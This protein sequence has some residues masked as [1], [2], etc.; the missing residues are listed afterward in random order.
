MDLATNQSGSFVQW[1]STSPQNG[2]YLWKNGHTLQVFNNMTNPYT[3]LN[4]GCL[5]GLVFGVNIWGANC[6]CNF[7]TPGVPVPPGDF[8]CN[9]FP[10]TDPTSPTYN[11]DTPST[12]TLVPNGSTAFEPSLNLPGLQCNL[13]FGN[14]PHESYDITCVNGSNAI[15][16]VTMTPPAA[17]P[18]F[19]YNVGNGSQSATT[20]FTTQNSWV[21]VNPPTVKASCDDNCIDPSAAIPGSSRAGVFPYGATVCTS[22]PDPN[23]PCTNTADPYVLNKQFC[24]ATAGSGCNFDRQPNAG[25]VFG[26]TLAVTYTGPATPPASCP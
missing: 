22:N 19:T 2:W 11:N 8:L 23:P 12:Y 1:P 20:T 7:Q 9:G 5:Q 25:Q 18:Y 3:G 24:A 14:N 6:G 4:N 17:G 15:F 10:D 21:L 16:S 26:G 13:A